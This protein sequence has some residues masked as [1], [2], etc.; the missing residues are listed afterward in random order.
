MIASAV[1]CLLRSVPR[2]NDL[3][4]G[5]PQY[6]KAMTTLLAE[7]LAKEV[8]D[9]F[10][11]ILLR[12]DDRCD[13]PPTA[14]IADDQVEGVLYLLT[15]SERNHFS[16][17]TTAVVPVDASKF[18]NLRIIRPEEG[19]TDGPRLSEPTKVL[20]VAY[21][22]H[23]YPMA[24]LKLLHWRAKPRF[25]IS[26]TS[27]AGLA[28]HQYESRNPLVQPDAKGNIEL[29]FEKARA[30]VRMPHDK[31]N[32]RLSLALVFLTAT[33]F[34]LILRLASLYR[35]S[36]QN[37]QLYGQGLSL[38]DFLFQDVSQNASV[39][40]NKY[41]EQQREQE[42]QQRK[43]DALIATRRKHE[44]KLRT[45]LENLDDENLRQRIEDCL[46]AQPPD[47]DVMKQLWGELQK[48][49]TLEER[50]AVLLESSERYCTEEELN[51]CRAEAEFILEKSGFREARKYLVA[52]HDQFRFRARAL[53]ELE[54]NSVDSVN[55]PAHNE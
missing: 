25:P 38:R 11:V 24:Y 23:A 39:A 4:A 47:V 3:L 44:E 21:S 15:Y 54:E 13:A 20:P 52:M 55:S 27:A 28:A 8:Q 32:F 10:P 43:E 49:L 31:I 37:F 40:K 16:C 6:A 50:L 35:E 17:I 12:E 2:W 51:T 7:E 48:T 18:G 41:F 34:A 14:K 53:E 26:E 42:L 36:S 46:N 1:A 5:E 19:W 22:L 30:L 9:R 45:A 29:D 33:P